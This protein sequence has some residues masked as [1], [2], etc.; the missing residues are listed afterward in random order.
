MVKKSE[1]H[2]KAAAITAAA[3]LNQLII[4]LNHRAPDLFQGFN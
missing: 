2:K 1:G 3:T 4:Y